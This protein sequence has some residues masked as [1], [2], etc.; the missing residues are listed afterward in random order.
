M[1]TVEWTRSAIKQLRKIDTRYREAILVKG[2]SLKDFPDVELDIKFLKATDNQYRV[3]VGVYRLMFKVI[4]GNPTIIEIY[5][6]TKRQSNT[7]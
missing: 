6:V 7:Y 5:E 1:A 2:N 3:R 4:N